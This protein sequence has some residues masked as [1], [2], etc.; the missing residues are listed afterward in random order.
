MGGICGVI[1]V[2]NM[3]LYRGYMTRESGEFSASHLFRFLLISIIRIIVL[4]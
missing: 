3:G 4:M 2:V 1:Q